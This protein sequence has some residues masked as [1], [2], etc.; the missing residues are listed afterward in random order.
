MPTSD[1]KYKPPCWD[2]EKTGEDFS[3][4]IFEIEDGYGARW[5][6][7]CNLCLDDKDCINW[8]RAAIVHTF[9][10]D[11]NEAKQWEEDNKNKLN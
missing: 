3:F 6:P 9:N 10:L 11:E 5:N 7:K 8:V 2:H 1:N 4:D